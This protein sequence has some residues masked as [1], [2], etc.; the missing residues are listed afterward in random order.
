MSPLSHRRLKV[1]VPLYHRLVSDAFLVQASAISG[2]KRKRGSESIPSRKKIK[3]NQPLS[4]LTPKAPKGLQCAFYGIERLRHS[5]DITH[6]MSALLSGEK[7]SSSAH[8]SHADA[9][10]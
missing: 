5:M 2:V 7:P 9:R 8:L 10:R 4:S 6:S 3:V 1:S